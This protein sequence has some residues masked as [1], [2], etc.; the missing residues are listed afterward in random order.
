LTSSDGTR[1]QSEGAPAT[2]PAATD[3][4]YRLVEFGRKRG[5]AGGSLIMF[6]P[7]PGEGALPFPIR[8]VLFI[9]DLRP[10]DVRG[11]HAHHQTQE[12]LVCLQGACTVALDDG[13]GR[14][15]EVRLC[16]KDE[17]LLLYPHVWRSVRAFAEG[18]LLLAIADQEYDEQDYIRDRAA[19]E[20]KARVWAGVAAALPMGPS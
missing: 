3:G 8:K 4:F 14:T 17:A 16:R 15:A 20:A 9:S 1:T 19:F 12:V 13:R 5:M 10:E 6:Q 11:N 2:S 18:T 7:G